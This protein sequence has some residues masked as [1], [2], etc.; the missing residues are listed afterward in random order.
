MS[1][2][3]ILAAAMAVSVIAGA[4]PMTGY[5]QTSG[6]TG[7][8]PRTAGA[9][10]EMTEADVIGTWE[11][12]KTVFSDGTVET[13]EGYVYYIRDDHTAM[14]IKDG[15]PVLDMMWEIK[16][17]SLR[18]YTADG[19][20]E[21]LYVMDGGELVTELD[22]AKYYWRR[23]G[24]SDLSSKVP[25]D[26]RIY[27]ALE[28]GT[29]EQ[30]ALSDEQSSLI[31]RFSDDG[32]F[33]FVNGGDTQG[34]S[35]E[36]R[37]E[38]VYVTGADGDLYELIYDYFEFDILMTEIDGTV[39][40]LR[41]AD[42]SAAEVSAEDIVGAW[43]V[44]KV[45]DS[46]GSDVTGSQ[47]SAL[48]IY[49]FSAD[50]TYQIIDA[51]GN[52]SAYNWTIVDGE[53]RTYA[54]NAS[55]YGTYSYDGTYIS[56]SDG[57]NDIFLYK[58]ENYVPA[59]TVNDILG[60]WEFYK[61]TV[62]SSG[63]DVTEESSKSKTVYRFNADNTLDF[64]VDGAYNSSAS[65]RIEDGELRMYPEGSTTLYAV[66]HFT[67]DE[68]YIEDSMDRT[69]YFR[70][71]SAAPVPAEEET[72]EKQVYSGH[73]YQRFDTGMTWDQAEAYCESLGGHL[74]TVTSEGEQKFIESMLADEKVKNNY[75]L[76]GNLE[77]KQLS[78]V[79][80]EEVTYENWNTY[81][82][83]NYDN[84]DCL[85]IPANPESAFFKFGWSDINRS[86]VVKEENPNAGFYG[87]ENFGFICEW[88]E[89]AEVNVPITGE[90][91]LGD[92]EICRRVDISTGEEVSIDSFDGW[93]YTYGDDGNYYF[94]TGNGPSASLKW[95][96]EDGV[97][98][99][100]NGDSLS[101]SSTVH[102]ILY[103]G[104]FLTWEDEGQITYWRRI[105]SSALLGDVNFDGLIDGADASLILYANANGID[106][107]LTAAQQAVADVNGDTLIDGVDASLILTYN[108]YSVDNGT[109]S[110]PDW[111]DT[112]IAE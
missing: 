20:D 103:D 43:R 40:L 60:D 26:W 62:T 11:P 112:P 58:D 91:L 78:W 64:L 51:D 39:F 71:Y 36:T 53:L 63:K 93:V 13:Y 73:T 4:V 55:D 86:G 99:L 82:P 76:G 80:G 97:I 38:K 10:A 88:D 22:G 1:F 79:T 57:T 5:A 107:N 14:E 92:W 95:C 31:W 67:D 6:V 66:I 3:K 32:S 2:K 98:K 7:V 29:G 15:V 105:G 23:E 69:R 65:W 54:D 30:K 52:S 21:S 96:I 34:L 37:D 108:A 75:W 27:R 101:E 102:N 48:Y 110:L 24:G 12:Y 18:V 100:Y 111:L 89:A 85:C 94:D 33:S 44:K 19:S 74:V 83:D 46:S 8:Y 72:G 9:S 61:M 49:R 84:D 81:Q 25:G 68:F 16:D 28:P 90:E 56:F 104:T 42:A 17:G 41:K 77:N 70:R 50:G 45:L 59:V 35:W 106:D 87:P 109:L 47:T